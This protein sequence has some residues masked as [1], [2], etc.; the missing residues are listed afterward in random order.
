MRVGW[1]GP[2]DEDRLKSDG[3]FDPGLRAMLTAAVMVSVGLMLF[4]VAPLKSVPQLLLV[5]PM[6]LTHTARMSARLFTV[7]TGIVPLA[8][9]ASPGEVPLLS[10]ASSVVSVKA[11][12][13]P[14][15]LLADDPTFV[16]PVMKGASGHTAATVETSLIWM[17][18][19]FERLPHW[20][21]AAIKAIAEFVP[22]PLSP[23]VAVTYTSEV[24]LGQVYWPVKE[25]TPLEFVV[26]V[27]PPF[28]MELAAE[29]YPVVPTAYIVTVA[30]LIG[31]RPPY[32]RPVSS[33]VGASVL[34]DAAGAIPHPVKTALAAATAKIEMALRHFIVNL[35]CCPAEIN[36]L[37]MVNLS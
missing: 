37:F 27:T 29:P 8:G 7:V 35:F 21:S 19:E 18:V 24:E 34:S 10:D 15:E 23:P 5:G 2:V 20:P 13:M 33:A 17:F 3:T 16:G 31:W 4:T 22:L 25:K 6:V 12:L 26:T 1:N 36:S 28:M 11:L 30:L 32:T 9:L 14:V